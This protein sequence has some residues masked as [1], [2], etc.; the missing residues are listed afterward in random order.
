[1][2]GVDDVKNKQKVWMR[3]VDD[4]KNKQKVSE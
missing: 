3:K 4:V 1:M 2:R